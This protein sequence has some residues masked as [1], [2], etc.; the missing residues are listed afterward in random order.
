[1]ARNPDH[2]PSA[3]IERA[4]SRVGLVRETLPGRWTVGKVIRSRGTD[5]A[6]PMSAAWPLIP[7]V[8]GLGAVNCRRSCLAPP[9]AS[10]RVKVL[11]SVPSSNIVASNLSRQGRQLPPGQSASAGVAV[12]KSAD[13]PFD[14]R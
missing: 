3:F 8:P 5:R 7:A 4:G 1:M 13:V 9:A 10:S 6:E 14:I 11:L 2:I 12:F